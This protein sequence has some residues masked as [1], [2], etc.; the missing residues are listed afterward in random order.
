MSKKRIAISFCLAIL[1]LSGCGSASKSYFEEAEETADTTEPTEEASVRKDGALNA[2][3]TE[4]SGECYVYLCGAVANPGVYELPAGSRIYEAVQ[5][6]GGLAEN[7]CED[8][9]NQ[10]EEVSDGQMIKVLTAEEAASEKDSALAEEKETGRI[11][12]NT[13]DISE[14]MT[15]PGIGA[16]KAESILSYREEKGGFASVEEIMNITGI[17]EGVYSK[18]KDQITVN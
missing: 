2:Y 1:L 16:S 8:S 12:I 4:T 13:A 11:N 5:M 15:L 9:I 3:E 7:A 17:K 18:I 6:A 10:A 14:L